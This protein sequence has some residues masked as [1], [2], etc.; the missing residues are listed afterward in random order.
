MKKR[1]YLVRHA[2]SESNAG[3]ILGGEKTPL[4]EQG[5]TQAQFIAKRASNL[6][7][8]IIISSSMFRA[9]Q[10][11]QCIADTI[12]K[13]IGAISDLFVERRHPSAQLGLTEKH[14]EAVRLEEIINSN[15]G[16]D[17]F[18]HSDEENF[19]DLKARAL[20]ALAYLEEREEQNILLVTHGMF[21]RVLMAV[22][23]YGEGL[24]GHEASKLFYGF[25]TQNTGLSIFEKNPNDRMRSGWRIFVWNDH[26]HLG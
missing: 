22:V 2:E 17:G 7:I 20:Q 24:T 14:P 18:R 25:K 12:G 9:Q 21:L 1:I 8:D 6:P 16:K 11:A 19:E 26:A 23:L 3:G 5:L 4:S 10:T 13:P 15:F